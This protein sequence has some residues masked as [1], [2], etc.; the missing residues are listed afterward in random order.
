MFPD[1][2]SKVI[3][4]QYNADTKPPTRKGQLYYMR[5]K[6]FC[7]SLVD[8]HKLLEKNADDIMKLSVWVDG[9]KP[10]L[11]LTS[12]SQET[13]E[14]SPRDSWYLY[15]HSIPENYPKACEDDY[16]KGAVIP[17]LFEHSLRQAVSRSSNLFCMVF[18][19]DS[20]FSAKLSRASWTLANTQS[21]ALLYT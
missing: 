14:V 5:I 17:E 15:D 20:R 11:I 13:I 18:T 2:A 19:F 6:D 9:G 4:F 7:K 12:E 16:Y 21:T 1:C 8:R 3:L 10:N